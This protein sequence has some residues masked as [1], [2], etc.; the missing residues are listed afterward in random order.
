MTK[1][2][3]VSLALWAPLALAQPSADASTDVELAAE[4]TK[5]L[6]PLRADARLTVD[7]DILLVYVS[8][9]LSGD[10]GLVKLG[11]GTLAAGAGLDFGFCGSACLLIGGLLGGSYGIRN[12]FPHGRLSYHL[13]LPAKGA[14][15]TLQKVNVYGV[16][17]GGVVISSM[18]FVGRSQGVE[19][20]ATSTGLGPGIGIGAGASYFFT[21]RVFVGAEAAARYQ[22]VSFGDVVT[23][24]APG[25]NVNFVWED[26]YKSQSFSGFGLRF[27]VGFR[28]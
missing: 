6:K 1:V 8:F 23:V 26:R 20:S 16:L 22:V 27:Y 2:L 9:G 10:F 3:F 25:S 19:V 14:N 11:P 17:F 15:N 12:F 5:V 24:S 21:E 7:T 18:G 13:E 28:I 4:T